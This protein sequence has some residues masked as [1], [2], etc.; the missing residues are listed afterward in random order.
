MFTNI[1]LKGLTCF[2]CQKVVEKRL[3]NLN[4]VEEVLVELESGNVKI[5]GERK[6]EKEEILKALQGT[7]YKLVEYE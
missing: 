3:K 1:K 7:D 6:M 4:G 2:A 5:S